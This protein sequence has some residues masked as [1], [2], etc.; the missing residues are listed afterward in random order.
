A[1]PMAPPSL[2]ELRAELGEPAQA[3]QAPGPP[4]AV[5]D[6]ELLSA[7]VAQRR[8]VRLGDDLA[9]TVPAYQEMVDAIVAHLRERGTITVAE[10]RDR[11]GT[12][13]RYVLA[14]LEHLDRE[15]V[16][17]RVGD[18]RVLGRSLDVSSPRSQVSSP[19]P[20]RG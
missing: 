9:F 16:T 1:T 20:P 4:G 14:L 6:E 12:S 7:L 18:E 15:H 5:L 3:A 19:P 8:I 17:R 11:F 10:V 13:R 2:A